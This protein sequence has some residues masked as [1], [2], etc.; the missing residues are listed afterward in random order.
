MEAWIALHP[1]ASMLMAGIIA[2]LGKFVWDSWLASGSRVTKSVFKDALANLASECKL[3]REGCL[4]IR[5]SNKVHLE[6]LIKQQEDCLE[7]VVEGEAVLVRRRMET[8]KALVIIMMT[9][10]KICEALRLD[11]AEL[12]KML[13]DMGSIE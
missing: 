3:R 8:R 13:V 11:C 2:L 1:I 7:G 10:I 4:A 9:Q 5:S 6:T 12:A